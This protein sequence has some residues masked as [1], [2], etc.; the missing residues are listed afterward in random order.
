VW[1]EGS[2]DTEIFFEK[3]RRAP[4]QQVD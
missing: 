4:R 2:N 1:S 3:C